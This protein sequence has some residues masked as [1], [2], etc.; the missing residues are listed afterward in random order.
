MS[1]WKAKSSLNFNKLQ[2]VEQNK[3]Y[4][5]VVLLL[6]LDELSEYRKDSTLN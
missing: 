5:V 6:F 3:T 2:K 4:S 1:V